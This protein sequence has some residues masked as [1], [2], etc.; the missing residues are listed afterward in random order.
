MKRR[1][2]FGIALILLITMGFAAWKFLGPTVHAPSKKYFYI[3]T[4]A[5]YEQVTASLRDSGVISGRTWFDWTSG[6]VGYKQVKPGRYEIRKGMSLMGLVRMLK[7]GQQS[8]VVFVITKIRTK[9][10]LAERVGNAFECDSLDMIQFLNSNDSLREFGLDSNTAMAAAM[11]LSYTIKWNSGAGKIFRQ[12]YTAYKEFWNE[13]R[14]RR[15][16][17][18]GLD[19]LQV[20]TLASIVD[21]ETNA[22]SDKPKVASVYLNRISK[23]MPLQADPTVKFAMKNFALK[24]IYTDYTR[25]PSPYNTYVNKGLPPG[26]ICTPAI[27]TIDSVLNTPKT[28][29]IYFV[30]SPAFDGTHTFT[31]NYTDHMKMARLYQQELNKRNIK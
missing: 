30:A 21:E 12:F 18:L 25:I 4:G 10:V 14:K 23:G 20:S 31:N 8:P 17:G 6:I 2:F 5:D 24:R 7:N 15:A 3:S 28:D 9:E 16:S 22:A 11:P 29:Y 19:P 13:E 1:I 27:S 26:P